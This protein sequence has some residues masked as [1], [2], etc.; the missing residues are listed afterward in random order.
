MFEAIS[1]IGEEIKTTVYY[2]PDMENYKSSS[3][4]LILNSCSI[5]FFP[6]AIGFS[7]N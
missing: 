4:F 5:P 6:T 7:G 1:S 3:G 2:L